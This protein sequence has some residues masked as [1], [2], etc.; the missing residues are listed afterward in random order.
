MQYGGY[1]LVKTT[2]LSGIAG[3][4]LLMRADTS[5][6]IWGYPGRAII[7]FLAAADV[8]SAFNNI[9]FYDKSGPD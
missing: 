3:A 8:D 6:R 1:D 4:A 7:F 2:G 9:L 5:F